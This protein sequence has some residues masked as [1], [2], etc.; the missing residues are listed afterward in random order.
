MEIVIGLIVLLI[1]AAVLLAVTVAPVLALIAFFRTRQLT[2]LN[3]RVARLEERLRYLRSATAAAPP[4]P[5]IEDVLPAEAIQEE[6]APV[7]RPRRWPVREQIHLQ[8]SA[9]IESFIGRR[10]LAWVAAALLVLAASFFLNYAFKSQMIGPAG[11][12]AIGAI[13]GAAL[14]VWGFQRH[15]RGGNVTR[16]ILTGA[17]VIILFF[18]IYASFSIYRLLTPTVAGIYLAILM[19][20]AAGLA[21]LYRSP[22]IA[23]LAV[24][25]GL[26]TPALIRS[27]GDPYRTYFLYLAVL[28]LMVKGLFALRP[29]P[30]MRGLALVGTHLL[31]WVWFQDRYHPEKAAAVLVFQGLLAAIYLIPDWLA[32]RHRRTWVEDWVLLILVPWLLFFAVRRVLGEFYPSWMGTTA[33]IF[34]M[35]YTL[36]GAASESRRFVADPVRPLIYMAAA[37]AFLGLSFPIQAKSYWATVGWAAEGAALWWLGLRIRAWGLRGAGAVFLILCAFGA[38]YVM[39]VHAPEPPYIPLFNKR[40]LPVLAAALGLFL[41]AWSARLFE[42]RLELPDTAVRYAA[43]LIGIGLVWLVLSLET[44]D[45]TELL[46]TVRNELIMHT[47]LSFMWA[48]YAAVLLAIGFRLNHAPTRWTALGLFAVTL[49]KLLFYDLSELDGVYRVLTFLMAAIVLAAA[50]WGYRRYQVAREVGA[51]E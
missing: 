46:L 33:L 30:G 40:T 47:A 6:T 32:A 4:V 9:Q 50:T 12:V 27:E 11:Q 48:I 18:S 41:A 26:L 51:H 38:L 42:R 44:W 43:G 17:G 8:D 21:V 19:A 22:T 14:C 5:E 25:G 49:L 45:G 3:A 36:F 13:I 39:V 37:L 1:V 16:Q 24:V 23:Y 7:E 15:L 31:F 10:I 20:E 2:G 35:V 34:A 28:N 29:W